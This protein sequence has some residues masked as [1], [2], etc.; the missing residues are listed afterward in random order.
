[1]LGG[2]AFLQTRGSDELWSDFWI[3]S[4]LFLIAGSWSWIVAIQPRRRRVR[5]WYLLAVAWIVAIMA[6]VI[7]IGGLIYIYRPHWRMT[8]WMVVALAE[9]IVFGSILEF[10]FR[11]STRHSQ[12][13]SSKVI[14]GRR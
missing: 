14:D 9:W 2:S 10:A 4:V 3:A 11:R 6:H 1:L 8:G 13:P 5:R 7:V 12:A